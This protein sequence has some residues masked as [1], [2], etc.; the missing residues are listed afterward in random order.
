MQNK[1]PFCPMKDCKCIEW[2]PRDHHYKVL[3]LSY[4]PGKGIVCVGRMHDV[5]IDYGRENFN[6]HNFC[7]WT[8]AGWDKIRLK[9]LDAQLFIDLLSKIV[10]QE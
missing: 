7:L 6:T 8:P 2:G 5:S 3:E 9:K 4:T 1:P 10:N